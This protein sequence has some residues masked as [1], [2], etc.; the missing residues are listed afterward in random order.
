MGALAPGK[1]RLLPSERSDRSTTGVVI[2][3]KLKLDLLVERLRT[4]YWVLP[5][6][7]LLLAGGLA[8]GLTGVDR[9]LGDF[10]PDW[11]N[12]IFRGSA[13]GAQALLSA[14]A[15]A[16]LGVAG[17]TFTITI[18]VLTLTSSQYGP[19]L[20]RSFLKDPGN[21]AVLG[22]FMGTFLYCLLVLGSVRGADEGFF[23][24]RVA[25]AFGLLLGVLSVAMLIYFI[26]HIV[27]T[28]QVGHIV[29]MAGQ[30]FVDAIDRMCPEA[31]DPEL[32]LGE[33][34]FTRDPPRPLRNVA[35]HEA[36]GCKKDGYIQGVDVES[37]V[38]AAKRYGVIIHLTRR[39]G[40]FVPTGAAL[41]RVTP[42][43][44]VTDEVREKVNDAISVGGHRTAT[45][46][47]AFPI[48]QLSD[49]A[50]RALS[51]G[52]NDPGTAI[53][54]LDQ[55]SEGLCQ[56]ARRGMPRHTASD[57]E[58]RV[59]VLLTRPTFDDLLEIAIGQIRRYG[60]GDVEVVSRLLGLLTDVAAAACCDVPRTAVMRHAS[61]VLADAEDALNGMGTLTRIR[62]E[63]R[64]LQEFVQGLPGAAPPRPVQEPA[65]VRLVEANERE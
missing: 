48:I 49:I 54:C 9:R 23:V 65:V 47:L 29:Q 53:M 35:A 55:L 22:T 13:G 21:Q 56:V 12:W 44:N 31:D 25:V 45:Q 62:A 16:V 19:R 51:P 40:D 61:L 32:E 1:A 63:E 64:V 59:R 4:S 10:W 3:V 27:T 37:L 11:L 28:I 38:D 57:D 52:I 7:C 60:A 24:P 14:I 15:S 33:E 41:A 2:S 42:A 5:A 34:R 39:P 8:Y 43:D 58:G 6:A 46:D 20:L 36:V 17:T 30:D 50:V 18:A 26:Q